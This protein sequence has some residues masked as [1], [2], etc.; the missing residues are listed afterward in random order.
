M[1]WLKKAKWFRLLSVVT[2]CFVFLASCQTANSAARSKEKL[3]SSTKNTMTKAGLYR[4][5]A[6]QVTKQ[7]PL[8]IDESTPLTKVQYKE[9][10]HALAYTYR[11]SHG[12]YE[13]MDKQG[14]TVVQKATE[15]MLK[16]QLKTNQLMYQIRADGLT[17]LYIYIDKN[18]TELF[19][20][21]LHPGEY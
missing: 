21:T 12:V 1:K 16:E 15:S 8:Q 10:Q 17:L 11:M 9:A 20:V 4:A 18:S 19:S 6:E 13:D 14:W 2:V 3:R 7:C 5:I